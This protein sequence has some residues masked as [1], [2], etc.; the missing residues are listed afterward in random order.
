METNWAKLGAEEEV[1]R[2]NSICGSS[3]VGDTLFSETGVVSRD[4]RC[5]TVN[6]LKIYAFFSKKNG[7]SLKGCKQGVE[8]PDLRVL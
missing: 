2:G 4:Q 8:S 6:H 3:A 1:S 7:T 5:K